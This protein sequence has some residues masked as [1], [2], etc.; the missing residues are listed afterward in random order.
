MPFPHD[1]HKSEKVL[2]LVHADVCGPLENA[3]IGISRY[4]LLFM[5][6]YIRMS[7]VYFVK[8]KSEVINCFKEFKLIVEKQMSNSIKAFRTD[9]GTEFCSNEMKS[10]LI[11]YGIIQQRT[12]P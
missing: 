3:S 11:Q 12:N 5:D 4:F 2:D 1:S 8:N 10:F 6:D 7:F 9:N